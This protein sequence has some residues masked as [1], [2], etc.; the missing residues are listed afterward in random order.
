[1]KKRSLIQMCIVTF[2]LLIISVFQVSAC[3]VTLGD[4]V[5]EDS[6]RN[7]RQDYTEL[8]I[9]GVA[10]SLYEKG[11]VIGSTVTNSDGFYSFTGLHYSTYI[12]EFLAPTN[13][14]FTMKDAPGVTEEDDSDVFTYAPSIGRT[15]PIAIASDGIYDL[16][17]DAGLFNPVPIPAAVWLL[18]S[19]L[20][21]MFGIRRKF[22]K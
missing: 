6:N 19:G 21:G 16:V 18:G 9:D 13:F 2:I 10:V 22:K 8:G 7:G 11:G 14:V 15:D 17:G 5:W 12:L 4:F 3:K 20:I 1:M